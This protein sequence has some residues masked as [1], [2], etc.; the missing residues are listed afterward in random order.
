MA[1]V[2]WALSTLGVAA[3]EEG[4]LAALAA[5]LT[6]AELAAI[7]EGRVRIVDGTTACR[8]AAGGRPPRSG[9][10]RRAS[11][12]VLVV[13][14]TP[15]V[16][17]TRTPL[18]G[19]SGRRA[20]QDDGERVWA[21][22]RAA[23]RLG[24]RLLVDCTDA[25]LA[26]LTPL[27]W[28]SVL[29]AKRAGLWRMALFDGAHHLPALAADPELL[30]LPVLHAGRQPLIVHGYVRDALPLTAL[31]RV[32]RAT[33]REPVLLTI[34]RL[35]LPLKG[36]LPLRLVVLQVLRRLAE[37]VPSSPGRSS[38]PPDDEARRSGGGS[39]LAGV[40]VRAGAARLPGG[41]VLAAGRAGEAELALTRAPGGG[42]PRQ[43]WVATSYGNFSLFRAG[44]PPRRLQ[45]R[46]K[47]VELGWPVSVWD[48]LLRHPGALAGRPL[49]WP[50]VW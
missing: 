31:R 10:G 5:R 15:A 11:P 30:L 46:P 39:G 45:P 1:W 36:N 25:D 24:A 37:A 16:F 12:E 29:L 4:S 33:G 44:P 17:R 41:I 21:V 38:R 22:T 20:G 50:S 43:A 47:V 13:L 6:P 18:A 40:A 42:P 35:S 23:V 19:E 2:G 32:L 49:P 8:L 3:P 14:N 7:R 26:R 9:A 34:P 27:G 28:R 48:L